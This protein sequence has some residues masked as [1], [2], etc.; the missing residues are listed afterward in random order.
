[1]LDV[2]SESAIPYKDDNERID[3]LKKLG[4]YQHH[5]IDIST[6]IDYLIR[7]FKRVKFD[8]VVNL[9][10]MPSAPYSMIDLER[11]RFTFNNNIFGTHNLVYMIKD[12]CPDAHLIEIESMGTYNPAI[13]TQIPDGRFVFDY[14]GRTSVPCIF[15]KQAGSQ[16]HATKVFS[17]YIL[18]Y[19]W[20][21]WGVKSTSINQ[22][23]VYGLKTPELEESKLFSHFAYDSCFGTV[24]NRFIVQSLMGLP[25][26]IYGEGLQKRGYLA[27]KDS[28]QCL[29]LLIE[30][31]V[32]DFRMVNQLADVY[33]I[34]E[35]AETIKQINPDV[36]FQYMK[37]PRVEITD[38]FHY[39]VSIDTLKSLGFKNTGDIKEELDF[40]HKLIDKDYIKKTIEKQEKYI[41]WK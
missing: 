12:Y 5:D 9:A 16:Y 17:T 33:N 35:I 11:A 40:L 7:L 14:K 20:R 3:Q 13:N 19:A 38:D 1:L 30:N 25:L 27:L 34:R 10:Q 37:S 39:D 36:E 21:F 26:T 4:K 29:M 31:P 24:I 28:V 2:G 18:D 32:N 15:P 23:V 22:G 41:T 8:T 6:D